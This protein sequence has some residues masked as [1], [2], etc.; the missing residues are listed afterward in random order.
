MSK[1]LLL[2]FLLCCFSKPIQAVIDFSVTGRLI[3]ADG[4][5]RIPIIWID[6]LS[7]DLAINFF[8]SHPNSITLRDLPESVNKVI[9]NQD[10]S[11]GKIG[12]YFDLIWDAYTNTDV[13]MPDSIIKFAYTMLESSSI[14]WQWVERIN[15]IFDA[16][17]VPDEFLIKVYQNAGVKKPIFVLPIPMYLD[18]FINKPIKQNPGKV[19]VFGTSA[20]FMPRKNQDTIIRAFAKIYGNNSKFLL[21]LHGRGTEED[22]LLKLKK[23]IKKLKLK[24]VQIIHRSF[25]QKEYISF[26]RSLD[27]YIFVSKGE[28]FSLTPREALALGIPCILSNNSSHASL[29]K[30]Q[31]VKPINA[32]FKEPAYYPIFKQECGF[33][34]NIDQKDLEKAYVDIV[35]NYSYYKKLAPS[36]R[37]WVNKFDLK[38]LQPLMH[39][40]I[41]PKKVV[42]GSKNCIELDCITVNSESLFEKYQLILN[43]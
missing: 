2:F 12:I 37:E 23:L 28:G 33:N 41:K 10:R 29:C 6:A 17:I 43:Q 32:L 38:Y 9:H 26:M 13:N 11:A 4:L 19:F 15:S 1:R 7:N 21:K 8:E 34:L 25:D 5:Y 3:F 18:S 36:G 35:N 27:C 16:V 40:L 24:N 42:F 14:P 22:Y 20:L 31:F 39:S 30:T